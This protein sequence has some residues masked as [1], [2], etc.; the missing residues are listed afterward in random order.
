MRAAFFFLFA[1]I[2]GSSF[3]LAQDFKI[4]KQ[5]DGLTINVDGKLFARYLTSG[6][7]KPVI[8]PVIGPTGKEMTRAYPFKSD[9]TDEKHDH[10]HHESFWFNHGNVNG[11]DFWLSNEKVGIIVHREF[12]KTEEGKTA[13]LITKNDWMAAGKKVC[14]DTRIIRFGADAKA[15]WIDFEVE[16]VASEGE[17]KFGE[18]KE[19]SFGLRVPTS[20]DVDSKKGGLI[21]NSEGQFDAAAWGKPA[22]WVDYSGPVGD[23]RLGIAILNHPG[24]FRFPTTWHVRTYGLFA[25]NPFGAKDFSA[26]PAKYGAHTIPASERMRLAY[27]VLLHGGNAKTGE[28]E[29]AFTAYSET[30]LAQP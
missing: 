13:L 11:T 28:I 17:L 21:E 16:V 19:G 2:V 3:A 24:S 27:R 15:R 5:D 25:A 22:K 6:H 1:S 18:T 26:D 12:V 9:T 14:E 23:E 7:K 30:K 20:M 10:V 29:K 8:W 4:T